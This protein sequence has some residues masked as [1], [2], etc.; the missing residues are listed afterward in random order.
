MSARGPRG[1]QRGGRDGTGGL[2]GFALRHARITGIIGSRQ[3]TDDDGYRLVER[4]VPDWNLIYVWEGA[5]EWTVDGVVHRLAQGDLIAVP[6]GAPH[7]GRSA[8]RTMVFGSAHLL[9]EMPGGRDAFALFALPLVR[10][11]DPGSRL[12]RVFRLAMDEYDRASAVAAAL[13]PDWTVLIG[14]ELLLHDAA[15]GLLGDAGDDPVVE[16]LLR[17]LEGA[18]AERHTLPAL[19][20]RAGYTAQHLNRRFRRALGV[21]PLAALA[22]MRLERAAALLREGRLSVQA[23]GEAVGY[24]D[25]AYFS[26][27]FR[28]RFARSPSVFRD[29]EA[30]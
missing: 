23:V 27:A 6:P 28:A 8:A 12:D 5:A 1:G 26:R 3:R 17:H 25:P 29:E 24:D 20:R 22:G 16:E 2:L 10:R 13:I 18:L 9:I 7:S 30:V 19:A 11:V 21:T 15:R 14:K 4:T